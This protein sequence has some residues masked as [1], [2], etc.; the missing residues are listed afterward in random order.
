MLIFK[1]LHLLSCAVS[2]NKKIVKDKPKF[3]SDIELLFKIFF[4]NSKI[5]FSF[6]ENCF[7]MTTEEKVNYIEKTFKAIYPKD[8]ENT[9]PCVHKLVS[10]ARQ[11]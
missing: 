8:I 9:P 3:L 7:E 4:S 10:I 11:E 6:A 2:C 1:Y 5:S